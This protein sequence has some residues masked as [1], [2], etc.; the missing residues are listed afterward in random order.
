[1]VVAGW[2][3][4]QEDHKEDSPDDEPYIWREMLGRVTRI[5]GITFSALIYERPVRA[6][7]AFRRVAV[8]RAIRGRWSGRRSRSLCGK[9]DSRSGRLS[10]AGLRR[11]IG[12]RSVPHEVE[13]RLLF[14]EGMGIPAGGG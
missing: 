7:L 1:M 14:D 13:S 10:A 6:L 5:H 4:R 9:D 2:D 11:E 8:R 3:E 12:E